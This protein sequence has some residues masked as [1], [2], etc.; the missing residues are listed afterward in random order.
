MFG[1]NYDRLVNLKRHFD[2]RNMFDK[3]VDLARSE[4]GDFS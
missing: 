3:F 2:P 4:E 1:V